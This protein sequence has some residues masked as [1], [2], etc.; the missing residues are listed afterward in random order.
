MCVHLCVCV[1]WNK[2]ACGDG[3]KRRKKVMGP[4]THTLRA[5]SW[6][7][8]LDN[9]MLQLLMYRACVWDLLFYPMLYFCSYYCSMTTNY[10]FCNVSRE[11]AS[12]YLTKRAIIYYQLSIASLTFV[13]FSSL[14]IHN[15]FFPHFPAISLN[16]SSQS[17]WFALLLSVLLHLI[18]LF[19]WE[20][21]C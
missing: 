21:F 18:I 2:Q 8:P 10:L 12:V 13:K 17:S 16:I 19:S 6:S 9:K 1:C 15:A 4:T 11:L 20:C 3:I 14:A 7:V 5:G